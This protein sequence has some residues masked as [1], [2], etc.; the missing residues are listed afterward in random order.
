MKD[1][2][3]PFALIGV[4]LG[5][6]AVLIASGCTVNLHGAGEAGVGYSSTGKAFTYHTVDGDKEGKESKSNLDLEALLD[7]LAKAKDLQSDGPSEPST[8]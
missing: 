5:V 8:N 3:F 6:I 4:A 7:L 1:D 2:S